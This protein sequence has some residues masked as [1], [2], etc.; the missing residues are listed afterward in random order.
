MIWFSMDRLNFRLDISLPTFGHS[1]GVAGAHVGVH[2]GGA[3]AGRITHAVEIVDLH[4][5]P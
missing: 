4:L 5:R 2:G 3:E 1:V